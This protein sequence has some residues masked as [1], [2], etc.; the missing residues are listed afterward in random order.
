MRR[1]RA[2]AVSIAAAALGAA[3]GAAGQ[4]L[5]QPGI[6]V[7]GG[8]G[9]AHACSTAVNNNEATP[10]IEETC[11]ASLENEQLLLEDRA[12]TFVN[13]GVV[14]LRLQR[15]DEAVKDF[16]IALS[17][18]SDLAEAY[19]NRGAAQIGGHH[20]TEALADLNKALAMGVNEP[21]KAY[22]NRALAYEW[23]DNPKAAWLDYNKALELA[24]DWDLVKQQL[25]RFTVTHAEVAQPTS[26]SAPKP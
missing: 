18:R 11:T 3:G 10:Q 16:T 26:A 20:F 19:V 7:L 1:L 4:G 17:L 24:P 8:G 14:R 6:T 12:G 13:R 5:R 23:L 15:Y 21:E 9:L 25:T 2:S 22:Y